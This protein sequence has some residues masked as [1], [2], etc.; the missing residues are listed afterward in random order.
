MLPNVN[1]DIPLIGSFP[2]H[3]MR[4]PIPAAMRPLKIDPLER[5]AIR[6]MAQKHS[7]KYSHGPSFRAT[8]AMIG[9]RIVAT[10]M[11]KT[12]PMKDAVIPMPRALPACPF[13]VIGYPSKQVA[14]ADE[15]PGIPIRTA[16][17]KV[18]ETPPIQIASSR[19]KDVVVEI[20]NV[21]GRRRAIPRVAE[22]PGMAP[23][24]IPRATIAMI[25]IKLTGCK[26]TIIALR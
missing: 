9:E 11:E 17:M 16:E 25:R 6:V 15:E 20:P 23:K 21:I 7:E 22:S 26:Q 19:T 18:P 3:P 5:D 14:M 13:C 24:T 1:L 2:K 12:D 10:M 8:L 4:R